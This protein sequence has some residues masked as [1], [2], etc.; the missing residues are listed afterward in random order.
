MEPPGIPVGLAWVRERRSEYIAPNAPMLIVY[1]VNM[2]TVIHSISGF[3]SKS[4]I[5][6]IATAALINSAS[7]PSN[8]PNNN[9]LATWEPPEE[10]LLEIPIYPP[11]NGP[12]GIPT[13]CTSGIKASSTIIPNAMKTPLII[14]Y[15]SLLHLF[16]SSVSLPVP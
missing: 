5:S 15:F 3:T 11:M 9:P 4:S 1:S 2:A 10:V 14:N 6:V 8:V 12:K 13:K 16:S 7:I